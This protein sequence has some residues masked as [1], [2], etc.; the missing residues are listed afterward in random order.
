MEPSSQPSSN[1]AL[2]LTVS[3]CNLIQS[4][5]LPTTETVEYLVKSNSGS[6]RCTS[7][8]LGLDG[9][10]NLSEFKFDGVWN[11]VSGDEFRAF[12]SRNS[13]LAIL[14]INMEL[15]EKANDVLLCFTKNLQILRLRCSAGLG[16]AIIY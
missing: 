8:F 7:H 11:S 10:S 3:I 4:K 16:R 14:D 12:L 9:F 5:C 6:C 1:S 15:N 13:K 2:F